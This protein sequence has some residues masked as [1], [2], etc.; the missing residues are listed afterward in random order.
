MNGFI[1]IKP[2]IGGGRRLIN[3]RQIDEII[4]SV[5]GTCS[6]YLGQVRIDTVESYEKVKEMIWG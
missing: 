3:I 6:I 4:E 2:A 5:D 1:E